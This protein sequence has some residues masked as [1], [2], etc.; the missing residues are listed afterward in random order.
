MEVVGV[1]DVTNP[2]EVLGAG[3]K[4]AVR[5]SPFGLAIES[6]EALAVVVGLA[7]SVVGAVVLAH[8][9][10][11]VSS[12]VVSDLAPGLGLVGGSSGRDR[13][14]L[15]RRARRRLHTGLGRRGGAGLR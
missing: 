1:H 15:R 9:S 8:T 2:S 12:L 10:L 6:G 4:R 14:W 11:A 3:A 13:R 5:S 7:G